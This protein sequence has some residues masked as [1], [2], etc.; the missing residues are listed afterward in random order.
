MLICFSKGVSNRESIMK[1]IPEIGRRGFMK[2][3]GFSAVAT[4]AGSSAL[5]QSGTMGDKGYDFDEVFIRQNSRKW[6][7]AWDAYGK[8][9]I[10]VAMGTADLDFKQLP[11]VVEAM[12]ERADYEN[13]GYEPTPDS[14]YQAIIDWS[15]ERYGQEIKKEW[16]RT[17]RGFKNELMFQ[18]INVN[19]S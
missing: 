16:I 18:K 6:I 4:A 19:A 11:A 12:K 14:F 13:Y 10:D 7:A 5:A 15:K 9:N 8:D 17:N 3:L 2:G 1:N